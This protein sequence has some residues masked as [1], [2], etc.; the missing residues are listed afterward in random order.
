L[1]LYLLPFLLLRFGTKPVMLVGGTAWA[2]GLA[3]LSI[4]EPTW[5]VLS[6]LV[7]HGLFICCFLIA[8]QVFVNRQATHDIRASA[9]GVLTFITGSGMLLGLL[10]VGWIRDLTNDPYG[11]AYLVASVLAAALVTL[12]FFGFTASPMQQVA[13]VQDSEIT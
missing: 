13:L 6:S 4:G 5:L 8:G 1:C 12:F 2:I 3:L 10:L 11:S 9:Q 7:T